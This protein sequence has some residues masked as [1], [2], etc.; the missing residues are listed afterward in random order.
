ML[1]RR[2][3]MAAAVASAAVAMTRMNGAKVA[4]AAAGDPVLLSANNATSGATTRIDRSGGAP[5]PTVLVTN[6]NADSIQAIS[7]T[8]VGVSALG[9]TQGVLGASN[10]SGGVGVLGAVFGQALG[11]G[12]LGN[13]LTA[14]GVWGNSGS[15]IGVLASSQ[16]SHAV[17]GSAA[18]ANVSGVLGTTVNAAGVGVSGVNATGIAVQA[19]S[20]SSVGLFAT[21]GS[22]SAVVGRSTTGKAAEFFGAV[23]ITG[24]FTATG[25]KS[26]AV[27][28][29]DGSLRR[30]YCLESPVSFFEDFGTGS[31]TDGHGG[32]AIDPVFASTVDLSDYAVFLTPSGD[33]RGLFVESKSKDGFTV[34]E[35][36]GGNSSVSFSYRIVAK[37]TG[38]TNE[39][40]APVNIAGDPGAGPRAVPQREVTIPQAPSV[41]R[42]DG[43]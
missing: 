31:I 25:M 40:L 22:G 41:N 16:S 10:T 7:T 36:M 8:N 33:C 42:I 23:E 35:L 24:D 39:R 15:N 17:F 6:S 30:M 20:T 38:I 14:I 11:Q 28:V 13:C 5:V 4:E 29:A 9:L 26:A 19:T 21:S 43:R 32:V 37:R 27:K 18:G 2:G 12:V 1:S 3:V 34:K